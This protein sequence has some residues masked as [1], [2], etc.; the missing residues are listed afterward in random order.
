M[1]IPLPDEGAEAMVRDL[2][3]AN[4]SI[5][6]LVMTTIED[7]KVYERFLEAGANEVLDKGI[8]FAQIL[9]AVRRLG[10]KG[11]R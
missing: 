9:V 11:R 10:A 2:H 7:P 3:R 8:S 1:D 4:P 6:V 5:P